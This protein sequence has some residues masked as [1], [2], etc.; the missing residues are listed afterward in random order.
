MNVAP[1]ATKRGGATCDA[2]CRHGTM[3]SAANGIPSANGITPQTAN[4]GIRPQMANHGIRPQMANRGI[5]LQ[6][7]NHG[8]RP[9]TANHGIR[10]PRR[11]LP[12]IRAT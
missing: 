8:I 2:R 5:L 12:V 3:E 9:Q 6:T 11:I 1:T 7:A 10:L 4:H